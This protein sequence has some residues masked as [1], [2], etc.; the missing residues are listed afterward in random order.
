LDRSTDGA[1]QPELVAAT[2]EVAV[3]DGSSWLDAPD[4]K[5][6]VPSTPAAASATEEELKD[7]LA[8]A[9][10]E[11]AKMQKAAEADEVSIVAMRTPEQRNAEGKRQAIDLNLLDSIAKRPK[12]ASDALQTR[13]AKA[14]SVCS[15]AVDKRLRELF[16]PAFDAYTSDQIGVQELD[17]RKQAARAQAEAEH[18]E[19]TQLNAAFATYTAAVSARVAAE[20]ATEKAM[21]EEDAAEAALETA[22]RVLLPVAEAGPSDGVKSE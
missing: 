18:S 9:E 11:V 15:S 19:L 8:V 10:A 14:R 7:K 12:T 16:Q 6:Y 13:V 5:V 1:L 21:A 22:V 2:W 17:Q 4:L 20:E 3:A